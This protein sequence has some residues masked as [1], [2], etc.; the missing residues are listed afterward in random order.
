MS[1]AIGSGGD[2]DL[3]RL[4]P[5]LAF[6][7]ALSGY[8]ISVRHRSARGVTPW[9]L[10]S[11]L[12]ALICFIIGPIGLI[13]EFVA[14]CTTRPTAT[15][16][17][18]GFSPAASGGGQ[19]PAGTQVA[20]AEPTPPPPDGKGRAPLFGWYPDVTGRHALRYWDGRRWGDLVADGGA[21]SSDPI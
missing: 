1:G 14:E 6:L 4:L 3:I 9:R 5:L 21:L 7:F 19:L 20:P 11:G 18:S 12:W 2:G 10:P 17:P 15:P 13:V 8:R 16:G